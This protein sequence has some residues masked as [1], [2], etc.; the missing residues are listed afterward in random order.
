[1]THVIND[2]L[3]ENN[4]TYN[5]LSPITTSN[6]TTLNGTLT[7]TSQSSYTQILTG[8]ATGFSVVRPDATTLAPRIHLSTRCQ[9]S[10]HQLKRYVWD[11]Y[12]KTLEKAQKQKPKDK[13][14]DYP[15][16]MKYL[17][18]A[19]P[20]FNWMLHGATVLHRRRPQ[21]HS[22]TRTARAM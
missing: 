5:T 7:L 19:D 12:R 14:D 10:I 9:Q 8:T 16:L 15:T 11:D 22:G 17:L 3:V 2:V 21:K 20:T 4:I 18:N 13:N 1:M 6:S